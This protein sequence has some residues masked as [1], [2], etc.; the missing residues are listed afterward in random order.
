MAWYLLRTGRNA[1][2]MFGEVAYVELRP[3]VSEDNVREQV[4]KEHPEMD[5]AQYVKNFTELDWTLDSTKFDTQHD[6]LVALGGLGGT[7]SN[8]AYSRKFGRV[9]MKEARRKANN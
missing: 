3:G 4:E 5:T 9:S 2:D 6:F 8:I 7:S 1:K